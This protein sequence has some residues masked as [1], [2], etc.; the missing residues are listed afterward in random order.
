[1]RQQ[2]DDEPAVRGYAATHPRGTVVLPTTGGWD[3]LVYASAGVM[4]VETDAGVWIVPPHRALFAPSDCR[5]RI[6][7][8]GRVSV[9]TLY[10]RSHLGVMSGAVRA[11]NVPP[12]V[13]ELVLHAVRNAPLDVRVEEHARLVG[14]LVDQLRAL[15]QAPLQLP[16]P[17]DSR[18]R[19]I[20]DLLRANV[21]RRDALNALA[22]D[23]GASRRTIE[24]VFR[25]ETGMT[26]AQWRL[27]LRMAEALRM[28][29][30][31]VPVTTVA[32][33]VGYATPSA[34]GVA[35]RR[36]LG[37]SPSRYFAV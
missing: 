16:Q 28:L 35:F 34:F 21:S 1:M 20:A 27:R 37:T 26:F 30:E 36:E 25:S 4:T 7:M 5:F 13:R 24:R 14:V 17:R 12:L 18:A 23:V 19:E 32:T 11:V 22:R 6:V 29:A 8:H 10:F 3:H 9:R 33:A 15:V 2:V 31:G